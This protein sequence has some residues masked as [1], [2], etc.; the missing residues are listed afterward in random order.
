[1]Y[2]TIYSMYNISMIIDDIDGNELKHLQLYWDY[3]G[4]LARL[5][6]RNVH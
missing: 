5:Q 3:T 2:H 1:M 4:G 6:S